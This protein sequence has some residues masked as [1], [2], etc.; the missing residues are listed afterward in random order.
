MAPQIIDQ[1]EITSRLAK[2]HDITEYVTGW[3]NVS[4]ESK[5][6]PNAHSNLSVQLVSVIDRIV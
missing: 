4:L 6:F 5:I 3:Q 2:D 1:W